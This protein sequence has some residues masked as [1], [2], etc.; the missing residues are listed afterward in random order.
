MKAP[1]ALSDSVPYAPDM[2]APTFAA[3]P[4]TAETTCVSPGSGSVSFARTLPTTGLA[5]TALFVSSLTDAASATATGGADVTL[6][7]TV[8]VALPPLPSEIS[9][10]NDA[11][12]AKS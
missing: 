8:A 12:P 2:A 3:A 9:Y 11:C 5:K 4:L 7:L 10:M 6:T 1:S